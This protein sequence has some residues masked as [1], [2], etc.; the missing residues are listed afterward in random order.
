[1]WII[2]NSNTI[3]RP[4]MTWLTSNRLGSSTNLSPAVWRLIHKIEE[5]PQKLSTEIYSTVG[6]HSKL[7]KSF[8][9]YYFFQVY[10]HLND[11]QSTSGHISFQHPLVISSLFSVVTYTWV[12]FPVSL[13]STIPQEMLSIVDYHQAWIRLCSVIQIFSHNLPYTTLLFIIVIFM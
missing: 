1:M 3:K 2:W 12:G 10:G 7:F 11:W 8:Q 5:W 9:N 6:T 4:D 13:V